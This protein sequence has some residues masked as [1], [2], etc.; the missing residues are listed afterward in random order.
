MTGHAIAQL[1]ELRFLSL[2]LV[3]AS[4][5]VLHPSQ[6][7]PQLNALHDLLN[8][9]ASLPRLERL[10][11]SFV[12]LGMLIDFRPVQDIIH[13]VREYQ[14]LQGIVVSEESVKDEDK[15]SRA[16]RPG[17][18]TRQEQ[19]SVGMSLIKAHCEEIVQLYDSLWGFAGGCA[20][21]VCSLLA[22]STAVP[23][24]TTAWL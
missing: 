9:L 18:Q 23:L 3:A 2:P 4:N 21:P 13:L 15:R 16:H 17:C 6:D 20:S 7:T 12:S 8:L 5:T 14:H 11:A 10:R 24:A 22:S 1:T 19:C